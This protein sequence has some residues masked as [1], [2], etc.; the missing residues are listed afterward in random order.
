MTD[1]IPP[2]LIPAVS[3][4]DRE[5]A[6]RWRPTT[7]LARRPLPLLALAEKRT[8]DAVYGLSTMDS[9]GRITDRTIVNALGWQAASRFSLHLHGKL[10]CLESDDTGIFK[11][12][13]NLAL[14]LPVAAQRWCELTAGCRVLLAA[15]P[16]GGLLVVHPPVVLD[17]AIGRIHAQAL[18]G[19]GDG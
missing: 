4:P 19:D 3:L 14:H 9:G 11:V 17:E 6:A 13:Q 18:A 15:Y 2:D 1:H 10:V 12:R 8:G 5:Q 16:Q 7:P